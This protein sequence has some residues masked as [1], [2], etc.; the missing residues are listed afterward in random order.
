MT[1]YTV[2]TPSNGAARADLSER[3]HFERQGFAWL[4]F[5]FGPLW[6]LARRLW[7]ALLV[8]LIG[9]ILVAAAALHGS[10]SSNTVG[11]LIFLSQLYLGLAGG[12]LAA[13]AYDRGRW[14]L[15]DVAIGRDRA[16]AEH[17]F[18]SRA[19]PSEAPPPSRPSR[20]PPTPPAGDVIGLF[21]DPGRT[22]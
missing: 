4:A 20:P 22:R 10:I 19:A 18:F 5:F 15:A 21:P 8:W 9:A 13:A 6:L 11:L 12:G 16:A 7:R 1:I 14:R 2:H 17:N 3:V